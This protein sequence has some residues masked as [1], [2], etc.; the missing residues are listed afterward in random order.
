[1]NYFASAARRA[2]YL[3]SAYIWLRHH[4]TSIRDNT[5][6]RRCKVRWAMMRELGL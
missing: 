3:R 5:G 2:F 6:Y 4:I 1:M